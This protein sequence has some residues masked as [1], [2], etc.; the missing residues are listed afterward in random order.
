MNY[1]ATKSTFISQSDHGVEFSKEWKKK[2]EETP[3]TKVI[4]VENLGSKQG[5]TGNN[6]NPSYASNHSH[7]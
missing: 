5:T 3:G 2:Q 6:D 7:R 1:K 4:G